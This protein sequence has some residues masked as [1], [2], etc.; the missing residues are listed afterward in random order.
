MRDEY[1][2][3]N[4]PGRL[5]EPGGHEH[6]GDVH[7]LYRLHRPED[8]GRVGYAPLPADLSQQLAEAIGYMTGQAPE[9]LTAQN[10]ANPQFTKG[11]WEASITPSVTPQPVLDGATAAYSASVSSSFGTPTGTVA[12]T[13]RDDP[14]VQR[15][16]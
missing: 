9:Q 6:D 1:D 5:C 10:C 15:P 8:N 11:S 14:L 3:T 4:L 2:T 13:S 16:S 7:A 12:F